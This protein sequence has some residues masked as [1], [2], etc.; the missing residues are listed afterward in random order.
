MKQISQLILPDDLQIDILFDNGKL[1][2]TF[3]YRDNTYGN[4]VKIPS[5]K[6]ADIATA[7][8]ILFTNALE[9]KKKLENESIS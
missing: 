7:C 1:A 3:E 6:V 4:A 2:Y 8:L 9:T 5:K